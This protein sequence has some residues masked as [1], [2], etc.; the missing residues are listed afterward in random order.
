[1]KI[2]YINLLGKKYPLCFSLSASECISDEFGGFE[3]MKKSLADDDTGKLAKTVDTVLAILMDAGQKYCKI[4]G[5]ECP[6]P[7]Q[8]RPGDVIDI[9]DPESVQAIFRAISTGNEREVEVA[10]KNAEATTG[11]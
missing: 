6:E 1:M 7:L 8:C 2:S 10:S 4:A 9:S 11:S 3:Q 5:I